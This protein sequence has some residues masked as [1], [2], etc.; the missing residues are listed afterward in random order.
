MTIVSSDSAYLTF[1][2][3]FDDE[4]SGVGQGVPLYLSRPDFRT[5]PDSDYQS[6]PVGD[7][8]IIVTRT[9]MKV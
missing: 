6:Y 7:V 4:A 2:F 1:A 5:N 3:E 9:T 8:L